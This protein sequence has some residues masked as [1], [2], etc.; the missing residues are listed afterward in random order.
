[1]SVETTPAEENTV[2]SGN[3]RL[4]LHVGA[5]ALALMTLVGVS[6]L[7]SAIFGR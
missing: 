2:G 4:V 1:M 6:P 7:G 3:H 5:I